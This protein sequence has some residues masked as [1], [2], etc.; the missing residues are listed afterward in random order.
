MHRTICLLF[1]AW[2]CVA[3]DIDAG[4]SWNS[5]QLISVLSAL[6]APLDA[7][8]ED[9][10][11][12]GQAIQAYV[13]L[14]FSGIQDLNGQLGPWLGYAEKLAARRVALRHSKKSESFAEAAPELWLLLVQGDT[15]AV[16]SGLKE[17]PATTLDPQARA[18]RAAATRDTTIFTDSPPT[19]ALEWF[20]YL[21]ACQGSKVAPKG[22]SGRL[23]TGVDPLVIAQFRQEIS[24]WQDLKI[25]ARG[26]LADVAWML[27]SMQIPNTD[28]QRH[29]I[30]LITAVGGTVPEGVDRSG[31]VRAALQ[32]ISSYDCLRAE[33]FIVSWKTCLEL[34]N[35]PRGITSAD[36]KHLMV[37]IGDVAAWNLARL[38]LASVL[39]MRGSGLEERYA[40][41]VGAQLTSALPGTL[42]AARAHVGTSIEDP[43]ITQELVD[44]ISAGLKPDSVLP[45]ALAMYPFEWV[46]TGKSPVA[47]E[48]FQTIIAIVQP[49]D[50]S[51]RQRGLQAL[52]R[53]SPRLGKRGLLVETVKRQ[54]ERDPYDQKLW[55]IVRELGPSPM[56][57]PDDLQP[58]LERIEPLV[59][60]NIPVAGTDLKEDVAASWHG[61]VLI[62]VARSIEFGIDSDDGSKL[63]IGDMVLTNLGN[64]GMQLESRHHTFSAGWQP[65]RLDYYNGFAGGGMRLL[66]RHA[67]DKEF[68]TIPANHL[69][70]GADHALGLSATYWKVGGILQ[71][72]LNQPTTEDV[73]RIE[74]MPWLWPAYQDVGLAYSETRQWDKALPLL[75][76]YKSHGVYDYAVNRAHLHALAM[77]S[78]LQKP[79]QAEALVHEFRTTTCLSKDFLLSVDIAKGLD[80]AHAEDLMGK[81]FAPD[82]KACC[83]A[84]WPIARLALARGDWTQ[85][86]RQ[87]DALVN[88]GQ[89]LQ[90]D[91]FRETRDLMKLEKIILQRISGVEPRWA[92]LQEFAM[93]NTA[94]AY[95][96]LFTRWLTGRDTWDAV[97]AKIP[98]TKNGEAVFY[99]RGLY[100]VSIG[101]I[102]SAQRIMK[103]LV[104]AHPNWY[105]GTSAAG[106]LRWCAKQTPESIAQMRK[107]SPLEGT[108]RPKPAAEQGINF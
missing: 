13:E 100:D 81:T 55:R 62:D 82:F 39:Q 31:L 25:P 28:A 1:L 85:A 77:S 40:T 16:V 76:M 29:L 75:S 4:A 47:D 65:L 2:M 98:N 57:A 88:N 90:E 80:A 95:Q 22:V 91:G 36:G 37:S 102:A 42:M 32:A 10:H 96:R 84:S 33:P 52:V 51:G 105:E 56:I 89:S 23:P 24:D 108:A 69:S 50:G 30:A 99:L 106:V 71:T 54:F 101:D 20:G 26:V 14:S 66:W 107:A 60:F 8:P 18:L 3:E 74:A 92:E 46:L 43:L 34:R 86:I 103:P 67:G 5:R 63:V 94:N 19:T 15:R 49:A 48:L 78:D 87:S 21:V 6:R 17:W 53:F 59:D 70:H 97:L 27:N 93:D 45:P 83:V 68:S 12:L 38:Y 35:A 64:H 73:E 7:Q 61:F 11:L 104:A 41:T 79:G 72:L 44:A 9:Q 58:A